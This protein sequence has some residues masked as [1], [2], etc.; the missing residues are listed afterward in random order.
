[1]GWYGLIWDGLEEKERG[2]HQAYSYLE[3]VIAEGEV[4]EGIPGVAG[5]LFEVRSRGQEGLFGV[6][7]AGHV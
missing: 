1:M 3:H 2:I 7:E 6:F 5:A 4:G